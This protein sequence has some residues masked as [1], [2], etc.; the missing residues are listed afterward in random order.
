MCRLNSILKSFTV[1]PRFRTMFSRLLVVLCLAA[2]LYAQSERGN[3]NGVVTD[4]SG[5]AIPNQPVIITNP[6]TNTSEHVTTTSSGEYNAANLTPGSYRLEVDATGFKRF[7]ADKVTLTAGQTLRIDAQLQIG[8]LTDT[9][10][11]NAQALQLQTENA[12]ISTA[13]QNKMVDN[14]PLVV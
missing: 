11:V 8:Q 14:L 13:V 4:S 2:G 12:K 9:V 3:I 10:E 7:V 5:A 6:A 1:V